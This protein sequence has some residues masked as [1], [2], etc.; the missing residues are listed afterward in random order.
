MALIFYPTVSKGTIMAI[1]AL[2]Y[3]RNRL[4]NSNA[5]NLTETDD[6]MAQK[7]AL[8]ANISTDEARQALIND[9][10]KRR[11][12]QINY[13]Q[14]LTDNLNQ[15][16]KDMGLPYAP[17]SLVNVKAL[18]PEQRL[19]SYIKGSNA[20]PELAFDLENR[21]VDYLEAKYGSSV[22]N[23][24][25]QL[26]TQT[27]ANLSRA[28]SILPEEA[29]TGNVLTGLAGG[30]VSGTRNIIGTVGS[31]GIMAFND[32]EEEA[33]KLRT[34]NEVLQ[35]QN[36]ETSEWA[37][38][39]YGFDE[40][41]DE[42]S[43]GISEQVKQEVFQRIAAQTGDAK[44]AR[45]QAID[46]A[47]Q[48]DS[49]IKTISKEG[50]IL[51]LGEQAPQIVL[52]VLSGG[53]GAGIAE[54][55]A[56]GVSK[57]VAEQAITKLLPKIAMAG[58]MIGVGIEAGLQDGT[59]AA[60]DATIGVYDYYNQAK[61]EALNGDS[62]KLTELFNSEAMQKLKAANPTAT[63]GEL[64]EL[65]ANQAKH[66]AGWKS[67]LYTGA[68]AGIFSPVL[69]GFSSK[70]SQGLSARNKFL[71][72]MSAPLVEGGTEYGEE[73]VNIKTPRSAINRA[74]GAEAEDVDAYAHNDAM[75]A[76]QIG[77]L[78]GSGSSI[79]SVGHA[80]KAIGT[81]A[82]KPIANKIN[83][84]NTKVTQEA[85]NQEKQELNQELKDLGVI[86]EVNAMGT[87]EGT[88]PDGTAVPAI[89]GV[90]P[91]KNMS[92]SNFGQALKSAVEARSNITGSVDY[93]EYLQSM[94][95]E[96]LD[97]IKAIQSATKQGKSQEDIKPLTEKLA[98]LE[99]QRENLQKALEQD[100]N[101]VYPNVEK[102]FVSVEEAKAKASE[103]ITNVKE[104][105]S[106]GLISEE[107][108]NT[109]IQA[110]QEEYKSVREQFKV[111]DAAFQGVMQL[112]NSKIY[113]MLSDDV[114]QD[115]LTQPTEKLS[116]SSY[117]GSKPTS[118]SG[119]LYSAKQI[120]QSIKTS[121]SEKDTNGAIHAWLDGLSQFGKEFTAENSKSYLTEIKNSTNDLISAL[122]EKG[123]SNR[124]LNA[125]HK[126]INQNTDNWS[127]S[128]AKTFLNKFFV[129]DKANKMPS[130]ISLLSD[131]NNGTKGK[132]VKA[133]AQL[134]YFQLS[135][136]RK[137][138]AL[139][140]IKDTPLKDDGNTFTQ[141]IKDIITG[142]NEKGISLYLTN[143][144][145][146]RVSFNT[147][148]ALNKYIGTLKNET[149][150]FNAII[151]S[152]VNKKTKSE[153]T[154]S[155][156]N[157]QSQTQS[158][159]QTVNTAPVSSQET[160]STV[161]GTNPQTASQTQSESVSA[162]KNSTSEKQSEPKKKLAD[163]RS[164]KE[165]VQDVRNI[166]T[167]GDVNALSHE[168]EQHQGLNKKQYEYL[169]KQ[170]ADKQY[171]IK[172]QEKADKKAKAEADK[173]AKYPEAV[174][175]REAIRKAL[176]V[177]ELR[178]L[179]ETI[180]NHPNLK[181]AAY[182]DLE[183]AIENRRFDLDVMETFSKQISLAKSQEALNNIREEFAEDSTI[184]RA[185]RDELNNRLKEAEV[186]LNI[187]S[188]P[189]EEQITEPVEEQDTAKE[190]ETNS[191][192]EQEQQETEVLDENT[193]D[194]VVPEQTTEQKAVTKEIQLTVLHDLFK[195]TK[196]M[197]EQTKAQF[198]VNDEIVRDGLSQKAIDELSAKG[199]SI[200]E[201]LV[202]THTTQLH[203]NTGSVFEL[204]TKLKNEGYTEEN[205]KSFIQ[206]LNAEITE[207]KLSELLN[208]DNATQT[209]LFVETFVDT[210]RDVIRYLKQGKNRTLEANTKGHLNSDIETFNGFS[211][212]VQVDENSEIT[213]PEPVIVGMAKAV[214]GF[215]IE[216]L[217]NGYGNAK[218]LREEFKDKDISIVTK[219]VVPFATSSNTKQGNKKAVHQNALNENGQKTF[220]TDVTLPVNDASLSLLATP[221][222]SAIEDLG[223]DM[224]S[225]MNLKFKPS[226]PSNITTALLQS[227]GT[228]VMGMLK[229][230]HLV[231]EYRVIT[232]QDTGSYQTYIGASYNNI[233]TTHFPKNTLRAMQMLVRAQRGS[234]LQSDANV[235][236]VLENLNTANDLNK[237]WIVNALSSASIAKS[238]AAKT[239]FNDYRKQTG[240][241]VTT[242]TKGNK[243]NLAQIRD[244]LKI[245]PNALVN[246]LQ[247][248]NNVPYKLDKTFGNLFKYNQEFI[249]KAAGFITIDK[250][251]NT[252][253]ITES[254]EAR[255]AMIERSLGTIANLIS[256]AESINKD[257]IST[258]NFFIDHFTTDTQRLAQVMQDNPQANK[259]VREFLRVHSSSFDAIQDLFTE[260]GQTLDLD[261]SD[262]QGLV[263]PIE[264][265][266][267]L[268]DT[269]ETGSRDVNFLVQQ[270]QS[271]GKRAYKGRKLGQD[272][273]QAYQVQAGLTLALAQGLG[274]KIER[275]RSE[276][277]L[278]QL[279]Q[280]FAENPWIDQLA[281]E[282]W[283]AN[284]NPEHKINP[285]LADK[286]AEFS[287]YSMGSMRT[288]SAIEAY[289][290]Y[291]HQPVKKGNR[292]NYFEFNTYLEADGIGNGMSNLIRQF[293]V[294]FTP[295][296]FKTLNAVGITT[297]NRMYDI[298]KGKGKK[299]TDLANEDPDTI[300]N[301]ILE[302]SAGQFDPEEA[303]KIDDV[304]EAVAK[305]ISNTIKQQ[306]GDIS[307]FG[308]LDENVTVQ[309]ILDF[310]PKLEK[311]IKELKDLLLNTAQSDVPNLGEEL[312]L[313]QD[314][315]RVLN[316]LNTL[317]QINTLGVLGVSSTDVNS[318]QD[319]LDMKFNDLSSMDSNSLNLSIKRNLAKL[320]VTPA[321]YGGQLNGINN[322][323]MSDIVSSVQN[324]INELIG[325]DK[326]KAE[327]AIK[328]L[329]SWF[330]SVGLN[331]KV[332]STDLGH[333]N[334][335]SGKLFHNRK[336]VGYQLRS[337]ISQFI[338]DGVQDVYGESLSHANN[339]IAL[340]TPA[341]RAFTFEVINRYKAA[342]E[343]RNKRLE[344]SDTDPR[345][346]DA[347]TKKELQFLMKD[348]ETIPVV[349]TAFSQGAITID[350]ILNKGHLVA[351]DTFI[352]SELGGQTSNNVFNIVGGNTNVPQAVSFALNLTQKLKLMSAG[353]AL[354]FTN[355]VVSTE[356]MVQVVV[357]TLLG[358]L[359]KA[360]HNVYDGLDA[361]SRLAKL[362]GVLANKAYDQTHKQTNLQ[363]SL[364]HRFNRAN[365]QEYF[366]NTSA[367]DKA[368]SEKETEFTQKDL[369]ALDTIMSMLNTDP[370]TRVSRSYT[371]NWFNEA[372]LNGSAMVQLDKDVIKKIK[373]LRSEINDGFK[374]IVPIILKYIAKGAAIA[375]AV[376]AVER[377]ILTYNVN[378][379]AGANR[380]ILVNAKELFK[381]E[382]IAKRYED[383]V[384]R[385]QYTSLTSE[386][387]M[388][389]F[390]ANDAEVQAVYQ[391][392][393]NQKL[394][395]LLV[396]HSENT[397]EIKHG[398]S[399]K[400]TLKSLKVNDKTISG[401]TYKAISVLAGS[402]LSDDLKVFTDTAEFIEAMQNQGYNTDFA[403]SNNPD[404]MF[405]P[406]V[407]IYV[408]QQSQADSIKTLIH[409]TIHAIMNN[410]LDRYYS[411]N[412]GGI[413]KQE[414][415]AIQTLVQNLE[416]NANRLLRAYN[417]D[418]VVNELLGSDLNTMNY[419][420]NPNTPAALSAAYQK[421]F[422]QE[423][424]AQEKYNFM[425]EFLAYSL[426]EDKLLS[427]MFYSNKVDTSKARGW[428][429]IRSIFRQ[430][431]NTLGKFF[432]GQDHNSPLVDKSMLFEVLGSMTALAK[433]RA[434]NQSNNL[435]QVNYS[436]NTAGSN[437]PVHT[438]LLNRISGNIQTI[439]AP[440]IKSSPEAQLLYVENAMSNQFRNNTMFDLRNAGINVTALEY[441]TY[442]QLAPVFEV[443]FN[444][445]NSEL[446]TEADK[447]FSQ[448]IKSIQDNTN[449]FTAEQF[450]LIFGTGS[451]FNLA[452]SMAMITT[453]QDIQDKLKSLP[454]AKKNLVSNL[455]DKL[456]N[457]TTFLE[458]SKE[459]RDFK[460]K[461]TVEKI[462]LAS[463]V[464]QVSN[465][466]NK[467]WQL[468]Q[469][470]KEYTK[471]QDRND[472]LEAVKDH[473]ERMH[474]PKS[475]SAA[476]T[477]LV[478]EWANTAN[479]NVSESDVDSMVGKALQQ[480]ADLSSMRAGRPTLISKLLRLIL[481]AREHT[482]FIYDARARFAATV[483]RVR[484]RARNII[485]VVI[486]NAFGENVFNEEMDNHLANAAIP[487]ELFHLFDGSNLNQIGEYLTD[488]TKRQDKI[489]DLTNQLSQL[490]GSQF[491][492][493]DV[494]KVLNWITWQSKG[495]GSL[496]INRTAKSGH[497]RLS[498]NI[499]PNS[500]AIASLKLL[501]MKHDFRPEAIKERIDTLEP[502]IRQLVTLHSLQ[503]VDKISRKEV[504][505]YIKDYPEG[506]TELFNAHNSVHENYASSNKYSLLGTQGY[507][508]SESDPNVDIQIVYPQTKEHTRLLALGYAQIANLKGTGMVVLR[509]DVSPIKRFQTGILGKTESTVF[510]TSLRT[511]EALDSFAGQWSGSEDTQRHIN[512]L[513]SAG[514]KAM[515]DPNYYENLGSEVSI[516]PVIDGS[517]NVKHFSV[518]LPT[519]MRNDLISTHEAGIQSI[520]NLHGR[521]SEEVVT[522][523]TNIENIKALN[524]AY[525]NSIDKMSYIKI[526]GKLKPKS[527][528]KVDKAF[529][530]SVNEFYWSLPESTRDYI[531]QHGL[532]VYR[533]EL[534][535]V[536][537]Y[538]QH[539]ITDIYTGKST[540]PEPVQQAAKG[541]FGVFGIVGIKPI[542]AVSTIEQGTKEFVS[543]GKDIILNRSLVVAAQ[544][545]ISNAIHLVS[546]GVKPKDVVRYA[547]EGLI[548]A[549]NYE[550]NFTRALELD[551]KLRNSTLNQEQ[552]MLM[553]QEYAFLKDSLANNPIAPLSEAGLMTSIAGAAG[554]ERSLEAIA[555]FSLAHKAGNKLGINKYRNKF[556]K[557][558]AGNV[559]NNILISKESRTHEIMTKALDYGDLVAKY[560]LYKHLTGN[561]AFKSERAMNVVREEFVN[562]S[563]NR[564]AG[565][566][567]LNSIGATWFASYALG[568]QKVI[569]KMLR[570]NL[571]STLATYSAGSAL[572]HI[573]PTGLLSTVPQ[574][575]MF[576]RS[577]DYATSPT[578]MFNALDSHYLDKLFH[579]MF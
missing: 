148:S 81:A 563:M 477:F 200:D 226:T 360:H 476:A 298:M 222:Y 183:A 207:D 154:G 365:L 544:N 71:A 231:E 473:T 377:Q 192:P 471:W 378:Q 387:M 323:V 276:N 246:A 499:L 17:E 319:I 393:F 303:A 264:A 131:V 374:G 124:T 436:A 480:F 279:E 317:V 20:D 214:L 105:F 48:F 430:I 254:L 139:N 270:V 320:G 157:S 552:K 562:Y 307:A 184:P 278:N 60:S 159:T 367:I 541:L 251:G 364:F 501:P 577:W 505:E 210:M 425:Q 512:T 308:T 259:M 119:V 546:V 108:A 72:H 401:K 137:V 313:R 133:L 49:N 344:Y 280:V 404:G 26:A 225:G 42:T 424:S 114:T 107:Q 166:K 545:L 537:G 396:N 472:I 232:D 299:L 22:A 266:F 446:R 413:S 218:L 285:E 504:A 211:N 111:D 535:N 463:S 185:I 143:Q 188:E 326:S 82:F 431:K 457:V 271:L 394:N 347:L 566:D 128:Q 287:G 567:Y 40:A 138:Q 406:N 416:S 191:E 293:T 561:R 79:G 329:N 503:Y 51:G 350:D 223:R 25:S 110:A 456:T 34:W 453:N 236:K 7:A 403:L 511:N 97:T 104:A 458:A 304:Y 9:A 495:L 11:T 422:G 353:G 181:Q 237:G 466:L 379:F 30:A 439:V 121:G 325:Q 559:V 510:G 289:A 43:R 492:P 88:N 478:N 282:L 356:S 579:M 311:R 575:N 227:F 23:Y 515:A 274:I 434:P 316:A 102:A 536:I 153:I 32:G 554:Y 569:Y 203:E 315:Y 176:T 487:T 428:N 355:T 507:V 187:K 421:V 398:S 149:N 442:N 164:M 78:A 443:M 233:F 260:Q 491:K 543:W 59:S 13:A 578:N 489:D 15:Q 117:V 368:L 217:N 531:E 24:A 178:K 39:T 432:F 415:Q 141:P 461:S 46:I 244:K 221:I 253:V 509:T 427:R 540:L 74:L 147:L 92:N 527:D 202:D 375:H 568:T 252:D 219:N 268:P 523:N 213:Y 302:G 1:G 438:G 69:G 5:D 558:K 288:L 312:I 301:E 73:L 572:K 352:S 152:A 383:Y 381:K 295:K 235:T 423:S 100:I 245:K 324:K 479:L 255:N 277:I 529:A 109:Q 53:I 136:N 167:M 12:A 33:N 330:K 542:K 555:D 45:K 469:A 204:A 335:I 10:V 411:N 553:E 483:E 89:D 399:L 243:A 112:A 516:Q 70:L 87:S 530:K 197:S 174:V 262:V 490:L 455:V 550:R 122:Q 465:Q 37:G 127:G 337:G 238:E 520:G 564:G 269:P 169:T 44:S 405:V 390:L 47:N 155:D 27:A 189:V 328:V 441:G 488:E 29:R 142:Y 182:D 242:D 451:N 177:D 67:G 85:K 215:N 526:D 171:S 116:L 144:S 98:N 334:A 437:N 248:F 165:L 389:D 224:L 52:A 263:R 327:P 90:L 524:Q 369:V 493:N 106:Q 305:Y 440:N 459:I 557:T 462:A 179:S 186:K 61:Q 146:N 75:Q 36:R 83:E 522:Q 294:G 359:G 419:F 306:L 297:L 281:D 158:Q 103:K 19:Q 412:M 420:T 58:S 343:Q 475:F 208:E 134:K 168:V 340:D 349:S 258:A 8:S 361:D 283:V 247:A 265:K 21:S 497:E 371:D 31:L 292:V 341:T 551:Y 386:E 261:F 467:A 126:A 234:A 196:S 494:P 14:Q 435:S 65:A 338:F 433:F 209:N 18:S 565:F 172:Q 175:I 408:N 94:A 250:N 96:R 56:L 212:L 140:A 229:A 336:S 384:N 91:N 115:E 366:E 571:L 358:S 513:L 199:F 549:Q 6:L 173:K 539:S 407:G 55:G 309:D 573:E 391:K 123:Y 363:E 498:H 576:D 410:S 314:Q 118:L 380:G 135:Q 376:K 230:K 286:L 362:V 528:S 351:K 318:L 460:D 517:G 388:S 16:S 239:V 346:N 77:A 170:L 357:N 468:D 414:Q 534:E 54:A 129:S 125:L 481:Q 257:D 241:T 418:P 445:G 570:R 193:S 228:E 482:Q 194:I 409:E 373:Q 449:P 156:Q 426:T 28:T 145:G 321:M 3:L 76:A 508:H 93:G 41:K 452:N 275:L 547:K 206:A 180:D 372:L 500:R 474:L 35:D 240:Y 201:N 95:Q 574:Q 560:V 38:S 548:N 502:V 532:Y 198:G 290:R 150:M 267:R 506:I 161:S 518:D 514:K 163:G 332:K 151:D 4:M 447:V 190:T 160:G 273:Q 333:L 66:E 322:Q 444:G 485:P 86:N 63:E 392:A 256:E 331:L 395:E 370:T 385:N 521:I 195:N 2:D 300:S 486:E 101:D 284:L 68:S 342:Q 484:E 382:G 533:N 339:L 464:S 120:A 470:Q 162:P 310:K 417:T 296:Y 348:L 429:F 354:N 132:Q 291:K 249:K 220:S 519:K 345:R 62:S 448:I 454:K 205:V 402:V 556:D 272:A 50:M 99:A 80:V 496:M 538:H 400:D 113:A 216:N 130:L 84:T 525:K 64:L 450:K 57:V 397:S